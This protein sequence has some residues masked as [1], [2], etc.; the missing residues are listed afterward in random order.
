MN[1]RVTKVNIIQCVNKTICNVLGRLKHICTPT[2]RRDLALT[3][4]IRPSCIRSKLMERSVA[5]G[6]TKVEYRHTNQKE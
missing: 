1:Y 3:F 4:Q 6:A 5:Y 2:W